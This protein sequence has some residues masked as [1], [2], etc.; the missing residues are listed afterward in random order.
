[1]SEQQKRV[2]R[3]R[4]QTS[5]ETV[6]HGAILMTQDGQ[7]IK[8][9]HAVAGDNGELRSYHPT[10][11]VKEFISMKE[12]LLFNE[13]ADKSRTQDFD[14][15]LARITRNI[16]YVDKFRLLLKD[17]L[18][19][20]QAEKIRYDIQVEIESSLGIKNPKV[21]IVSQPMTFQA[22][23][24][25]DEAE[26]ETGSDADGNDDANS[27]SE[28]AEEASTGPDLSQHIGLTFIISPSTGT[29]L[30]QLEA[31]TEIVARFADPDEEQTSGYMIEQ[32][33]KTAPLP[34][35]PED[36]VEGADGPMAGD[37]LLPD[38]GAPAPKNEI[39]ATVQSL[40]EQPDGNTLIYLKLPGDRDGY[41]LE[42]EKSIKV[43]TVSES[44]PAPEEEKAAPAANAADTAEGG[45]P[46]AGSGSMPILA[47][48]GAVAV[49]LI[50]LAFF[51][52]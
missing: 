5:E 30:A 14:R 48:A 50:L 39:Q 22:D 25:A 21:H 27:D 35:S 40:E 51:L 10:D 34:E 47:I 20:K 4:V 26:A 38:D 43:K 13:K 24:G 42:E 31:G 44:Q 49:F 33:L 17:S 32:G 28:P 52:A 3:I 15:L 9:H 1:M 18:K 41:I 37:G 2:I 11:P 45:A 29:P 23:G 7:Q 36:G 16:D 12:S 8:E 19:E 46:A 6:Y